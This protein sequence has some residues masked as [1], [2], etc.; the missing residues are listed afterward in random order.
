MYKL[1]K[2]SREFF[3]YT[4][5]FR[6]T[7]KMI[8]LLG[9]LPIT[10]RICCEKKLRR[11]AQK[12]SKKRGKE[13]LFK[14]PFGTFIAKTPNGYSVLT[15]DYETPV[16]RIM[17][18]N[19]KRNKDKKRAFINIWCHIGRWL[20]E[21]VK[22][23]G[24]EWVAFEPSKETFRYLKINT[25]LSGIEDKTKLYNF[26]LSDIAETKRFTYIQH[27]DGHS[28]ILQENEI[29]DDVISIETKVFD[30]LDLGITPEEMKLIMIDVEGHEYQV[31][32]WMKETLRRIKDVDIIV[33]IFDDD[34]NREK[35]LELMQELWFKRE[36]IT[37]AD[38][39][40]QKHH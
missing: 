4:G 7:M 22:V 15:K 21:F 30:D 27:H 38:Y 37:H 17:V 34:P 39:L 18:R 14:T 33:E 28:H 9:I 2:R 13:T 1:A 26:W 20:V 16:K 19:Y 8:I 6:F 12:L 23:Y 5:S 36:R 40:F 11:F 29:A 32:K 35:T 24:Y 31:L 10:S 3:K 25:L